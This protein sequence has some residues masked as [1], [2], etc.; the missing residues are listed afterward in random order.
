MNC[1]DYTSLWCTKLEIKGLFC[2][3]LCKKVK[4]QYVENRQGGSYSS[5]ITC[6]WLLKCFKICHFLFI[7]KSKFTYSNFLACNFVF[8][9][10]NLNPFTGHFIK[11]NFYISE[12]CSVCLQDVG[13]VFFIFY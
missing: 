6:L 10:I 7:Q 1:E 2:E 3:L 8:L 11:L 12:E 5:K 9:Y 13:G 4:L